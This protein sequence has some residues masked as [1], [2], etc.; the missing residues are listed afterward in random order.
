MTIL[1]CHHKLQVLVCLRSLILHFPICVTRRPPLV[2]WTPLVDGLACLRP[3]HLL[4]SVTQIEAPTLGLTFSP[5]NT[6]SSSH[7][8]NN[9]PIL[10]SLCTR[11]SFPCHP[12]LLV[13]F[14]TN[15]WI[16]V[17]TPLAI[18]IVL[19]NVDAVFK[20]WEMACDLID[21][22]DH[23]VAHEHFVV[24][25]ICL[26]PLHVLQVFLTFLGVVF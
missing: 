14:I 4:P 1:V 5:Y 6:W 25:G 24:H 12:K 10:T 21:D 8:A 18:A 19:L 22:V 3:R 26:S 7:A 17:A 16:F 2:S 15:Q 20:F 23:E 13:Y 11:S 9:Y